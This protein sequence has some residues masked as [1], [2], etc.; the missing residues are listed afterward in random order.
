MQRTELVFAC[1]TIA[2]SYLALTSTSC[3]V[4]CARV[5][6]CYGNLW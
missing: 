6:S 1:H 3:T 4:Q 2:L 5:T